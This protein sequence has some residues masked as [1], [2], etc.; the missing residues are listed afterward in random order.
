MPGLAAVT[1]ADARKAAQAHI[2]PDAMRVIVVGDVKTV[3]PQ[4]RALLASGKLG[5]GDIVSLDFDG[6]VAPLK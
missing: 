5:K 3:V 1:A 2:V 6:V 4:L